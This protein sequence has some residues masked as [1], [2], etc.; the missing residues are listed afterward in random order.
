MLGAATYP[1]TLALVFGVLFVLTFMTL[2]SVVR[3]LR[4]QS[5]QVRRLAELIGQREHGVA[6]VDG[7][8]DGGVTTVLGGHE[9]AR[10]EQEI[11]DMGLKLQRL[12]EGDVNQYKISGAR[13]LTEAVASARAGVAADEIARACGMSTGEAELLVRLH[14]PQ[15]QQ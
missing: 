12:L 13:S 6:A 4:E 2:L 7:G 10:L 14:S 11:S 3:R 9:L 1:S 15:P 8:V 5:G